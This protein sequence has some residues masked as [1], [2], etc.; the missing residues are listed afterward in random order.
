[1][2]IRKGELQEM[3]IGRAQLRSALSNLSVSL[4]ANV[5][6]AGSAALIIYQE[7]RNALIFL[8][9]SIVV[10]LNIVR[11]GFGIFA[12]RQMETTETPQRILR[13]L[14]TFALI[15][16]LAWVPLPV[17]FLPAIETRTA[18]Y[19][20]FIMAG[21]ATGAIIQSL[22]YWR[23]SIAFGGPILSTTILGLLLQG[24]TIDYVVAVNVML[25]M[26]MLFR[27]AII[28]E[29][30]FR[31]N[32]AT[33]LQATE[34][35]QSL[36]QANEEVQKANETLK[37]LA[38]TDPLTGLP[39]RSVFNQRLATLIHAKAAVSLALIDIDHFKQINDN[40]GHAVG[41]DILCSLALSMLDRADEHMTPVRLGGDEFALIA[42]GPGGLDRLKRCMDQIRRGLRELGRSRELPTAT[43]SVGL[44][45]DE[46]GSMT[47]ADLFS[48]TDRALYAAKKAGRNCVRTAP[49]LSATSRS[50]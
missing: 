10:L 27:I 23:I 15:G 32:Q 2:D 28:S 42:E 46:G 21:I 31:N 19:L 35:A 43:I 47:A 9:L 24:Q 6:I 4:T 39:N 26:A 5:F 30:N 8:W 38:T 50:A 34:L 45:S 48:E 11:L 16:G 37:R 49:A 36:Q 29:A 14:A 13:R 12:R 1:M 20:V 3:A 44:C 22:A 33:T 25:L 18:A 40:S 17:Y 7:Q 41:D